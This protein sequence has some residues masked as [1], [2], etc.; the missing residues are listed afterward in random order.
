MA[1]QFLLLLGSEVLIDWLKHAF[2]SKFNGLGPSVYDESLALLG[3]ELEE[4]VTGGRVA[5]LAR[6]YGFTAI[7]S[8]VV[9]AHVAIDAL[10][11]WPWAAEVGLVP[12][13]IGA[14]V[15]VIV[16]ALACNLASGAVI[17]SLVPSLGTGTPG[18][19]TPVDNPPD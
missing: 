9:A 10:V 2:I 6:L 8:T 13:A 5:T 19:A 7:P 12:V 17:E 16:G 3:S 1:P 15:L 11:A 18:P 14:A 4:G